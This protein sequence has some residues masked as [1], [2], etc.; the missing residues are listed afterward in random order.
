MET[1]LVQGWDH[2]LK[3]KIKR[4]RDISEI[5]SDRVHHVLNVTLVLKFLLGLKNATFEI[6]SYGKMITMPS[7]FVQNHY[8]QE[9]CN[10]E[11]TYFWIFV[12]KSSFITSV[13]DETRADHF[14]ADSLLEFV[15]V[16]LGVF[17]FQKHSIL[18][19]FY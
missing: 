18:A 7:N 17:S 15:R 13:K 16:T 11:S 12:F 3:L 14:G 19:V 1:Q 2:A 9:I 4:L 8:F 5:C 6:I 10:Y